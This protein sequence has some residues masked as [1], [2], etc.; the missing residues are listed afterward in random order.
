MSSREGRGKE[1]WCVALCLVPRAGL[2]ASVSLGG[3]RLQGQRFRRACVCAQDRH[4]TA[5]AGEKKCKRNAET[6]LHMSAKLAHM[7][8]RMPTCVRVG[9]RVC[10]HAW[11]C[12]DKTVPPSLRLPPTAL[13]AHLLC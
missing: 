9:C 2:F 4:H 10:T 5:Y 11:C 8:G 7:R 3:R 6:A 1:V 12:S 13:H